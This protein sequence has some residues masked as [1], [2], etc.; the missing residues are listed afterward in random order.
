MFCVSACSTLFNEP[1]L[2]VFAVD[3]F[4]FLNTGYKSKPHNTSTGVI[5]FVTLRPGNGTKNSMKTVFALGT[6]VQKC[7]K[8]AHTR[9]CMQVHTHTPTQ[10]GQLYSK[11]L[12]LMLND[13]QYQQLI[14]GKS[15][16]NEAQEF[17]KMWWRL[18]RIDV[19]EYRN[20]KRNLYPNN[21]CNSN[22][23]RGIYITAYWTSW[24][25]QPEH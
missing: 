12:N 25:H 9:T 4:F 15:S 21:S 24:W 11:P 22:N 8:K 3:F 7:V 16:G 20:L 1:N 14:F 19:E 17:N 10:K 6:W 5:T 23:R 13:F 18:D 2:Y